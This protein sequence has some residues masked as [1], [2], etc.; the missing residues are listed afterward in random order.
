V[1]EFTG[2]DGSAAAWTAALAGVE[3]VVFP[4]TE[5]GTLYATGVD[6]SDA[7]LSDAAAVALGTWVQGGGTVLLSTITSGDGG[8][9][10]SVL[11]GVDYTGSW[12]TSGGAGSSA[13]RVIA[14]ASLPA[15]LPYADGTY[16]VN[17]SAWTPEQLDPLTAWYLDGGSL[18]AGE[19]AAG[20]GTIAVESYDYYPEPGD[21]GNCDVGG[22]SQSSLELIHQ[23]NI[24]VSGLLD[25]GTPTDPATL[26][27]PAWTGTGIPVDIAVSFGGING[28][29]SWTQDGPAQFQ[30]DDRPVG[31]GVELSEWDADENPSDWYGCFAVDVDADA[32]TI[33]V[34]PIVESDYGALVVEVTSP[35]LISV[36]LESDSLFETGDDEGNN[37]GLDW[38]FD[39]GALSASWSDDLS[40]YD[41]D[42]EAD[43]A[44]TA[45]NGA[46][47]F[48]YTVASDPQL[49]AT[50]TDDVLAPIAFALALLGLGGLAVVIRRRV[51]T[52]A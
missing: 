23:W 11:S 5:R 21:S 44:D 6:G 32:Q 31:P 48:S 43:W 28:D 3:S 24:V 37:W 22:Q 34:T 42:E 9:L 40:L 38:S 45:E 52:R 17:I 41:A 51:S 49:A 12:N 47:V 2:G 8:D 18:W 25:G 30:V 29:G 35:Q 14:D 15:T 46:A 39:S 4:E 26:T 50:G 36:S 1:T 10:V 19:I 20:D 27:E 33:T 13:P 7:W 16:P